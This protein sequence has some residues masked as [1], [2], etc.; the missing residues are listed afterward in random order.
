MSKLFEILLTKP[1]KNDKIN[2]KSKS[3]IFKKGEF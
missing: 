1:D 3:E 2:I